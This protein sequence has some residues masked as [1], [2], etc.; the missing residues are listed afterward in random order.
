[1]YRM[2]EV[3]FTHVPHK[4]MV[5]YSL[6]VSLFVLN[7]TFTTERSVSGFVIYF[8]RLVFEIKNQELPEPMKLNAGSPGTLVC[9]TYKVSY[10]TSHT[11]VIK[12]HLP[13][14][15]PESSEPNMF[16]CRTSPVPTIRLNK[17]LNRKDWTSITKYY[18][19][20]I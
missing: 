6:G 8:R 3:L 16:A 17:V 12:Q 14:W 15:V 19:H 9:P 4:K 20:C 11:T 2:F 5:W 13:K 1:M 7:K 10:V 18:N